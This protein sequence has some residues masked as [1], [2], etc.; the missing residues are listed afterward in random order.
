MEKC[1]IAN[2]CLLTTNVI[3]IGVGIYYVYKNS[4]HCPLDIDINTIDPNVWL[5]FCK[6]KVYEIPI[7]DK[8]VTK[9]NWKETQIVWQYI[10]SKDYRSDPARNALK[11]CIESV[12]S[13][14]EDDNADRL[15]SSV[16]AAM[17]ADFALKYINK[18]T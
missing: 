10:V 5:A 4:Q 3:A 6:K 9:D 15:S 12:K 8:T 13:F 11:A 17:C 2:I 1:Q 7:N 14:A 16:T 18:Q